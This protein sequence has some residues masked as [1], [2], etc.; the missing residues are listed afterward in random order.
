MNGAHLH[1]ILNHIPI[2]GSIFALF[3]LSYGAFYKNRS[4]SNAGLVTIV[5]AALFAIP[6]YLSGEEAEHAVDGITGVSQVA[7]ETHEDHAEI[8]LWVM[9]MSGAIALGT[10]LSTFKNKNTSPVLLW[11]NLG[12]L[13]IVVLLMVRTGNSGGTIHHPEIDSEQLAPDHEHDD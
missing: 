10:L 8:A 7:I 4:I 11:I 5:I 3:L 12:L 13:I 1:L 6:V 9:L 2:L